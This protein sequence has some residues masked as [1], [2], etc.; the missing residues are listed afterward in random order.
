[1][2]NLNNFKW[3]SGVEGWKSWIKVLFIIQGKEIWIKVVFV[4]QGKEI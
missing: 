1:M 2:E 3:F 4:I